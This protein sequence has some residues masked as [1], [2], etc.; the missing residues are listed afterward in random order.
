MV[1]RISVLANYRVDNSFQ[2]VLFR[3]HALH[4]LNQLVSLVNLVVFEVVDHEIKTCFRDYVHQRRKNLQR[5]F[6][7][8]KHDQIM[9]KKVIVLEDIADCASILERFQL[10]FCG[11][12]IVE[13]EVV[14]SLE[15]DADD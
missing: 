9:A 10:G 3:Q 7:S 6:T 14:T 12:P 15:V 1:F 5:I 13:L 11:L 8:T 4:V 2:D